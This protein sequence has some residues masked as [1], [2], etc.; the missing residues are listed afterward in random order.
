MRNETST[1]GG[2]VD[3]ENRIAEE[4]LQSI[5]PG[6]E[7]DEGSI[8]WPMLSQPHLDQRIIA[9]SVMDHRNKL[10]CDCH[11]YPRVMLEPFLIT[12]SLEWHIPI[13]LSG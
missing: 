2:E 13:L 4:D 3:D 8:P 12:C 11:Y 7:E 10:V 9:T 6:L 1:S 5:D